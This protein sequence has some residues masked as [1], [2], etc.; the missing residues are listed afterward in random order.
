MYHVFPNGVRDD[1]IKSVLC[2]GVLYR[3]IGAGE[4]D[5]VA[6]QVFPTVRLDHVDAVGI[7]AK[8]VGQ[9]PRL[10]GVSASDL[11]HGLLA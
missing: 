4:V 11:K 10:V 2:K 8:I 9:R 1:S 5:S 3:E 7:T 6:P